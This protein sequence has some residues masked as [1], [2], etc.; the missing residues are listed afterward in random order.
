ML[1]GGDAGLFGSKILKFSPGPN[2]VDGATMI[3]AEHAPVGRVVGT[4]VLGFGLN[5]F[6]SVVFFEVATSYFLD[7]ARCLSSWIGL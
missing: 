7:F 2:V 1:A 5:C 6:G 3:A 4:R